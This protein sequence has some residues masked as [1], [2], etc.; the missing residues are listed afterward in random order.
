[1]GA[2]DASLRKLQCYTSSTPVSFIIITHRT[3]WLSWDV[4]GVLTTPNKRSSKNSG[5]QRTAQLASIGPL[6]Y[7]IQQQLWPANSDSCIVVRMSSPFP[8][9]RKHKPEISPTLTL[10]IT[11]STY[12]HTALLVPTDSCYIHKTLSR[13]FDNSIMASA[14]ACRSQTRCAR[15][16]LVWNRPLHQGCVLTPLTVQHLLHGGYVHDIYA[17][18][19]LQRHLGRSGAS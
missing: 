14:H 16:N 1:M 15:G 12:N 11:V 3:L 2:L 18:Q 7:Y 9:H 17:F 19:G 5:D 6:D 4:S 13:P 10:P 8:R